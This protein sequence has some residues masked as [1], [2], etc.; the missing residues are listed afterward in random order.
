MK[1]TF[2]GGIERVTGSCNWLKTDSVEFLVDCGMIQGEA[3]DQF[4]NKQPFPFDPKKIKFMFLTHAHLDHCGL[5]PRLYKEGFVGS[6]L[7]TRATGKLAKEIMLDA[8]KIGA[9][10]K[11]EDVY[12]VHFS[13]FDDK[14]NFKWGIMTPFDNDLFAAIYRSSH[15]LGSIS[16]SISWKKGEEQK[17]IFFTGG[18][19]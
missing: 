7:C 9:P 6:V 16:I 13:Y 5:I 17:S 1:V 19:E 18:R 12:K 3:H 11:Q 14:E 4:E 10:Y 15:I 2:I 8:A